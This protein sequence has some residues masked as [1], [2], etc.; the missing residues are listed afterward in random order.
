MFNLMSPLK[1]KSV[2]FM[3]IESEQIRKKTPKG[4]FLYDLISRGRKGIKIILERT[5]LIM[6]DWNAPFFVTS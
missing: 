6:I 5:L 2:S 4:P 3:F 1:E